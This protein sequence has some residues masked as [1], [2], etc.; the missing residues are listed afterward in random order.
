MKLEE[1]TRSSGMEAA[2]CEGTQV[3]PVTLPGDARLPDGTG[4]L[5]RFSL[6]IK[7]GAPVLG[8]P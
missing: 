4:A 7:K 5:C 2:A 3:R 8:T 6:G 1:Q